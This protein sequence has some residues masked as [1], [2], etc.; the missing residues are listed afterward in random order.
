MHFNGDFET[1]G[2]NYGVLL[3]P[4]PGVFES[5]SSPLPRAPSLP[6][7]ASAKTRH[8]ASVASRCTSAA[9]GACRLLQF[10]LWGLTLL[11]TWKTLF[12]KHKSDFSFNGRCWSVNK[13]CVV[14]CDSPALQSRSTELNVNMITIKQVWESWWRRLL[15]PTSDKQVQSFKSLGVNWTLPGEIQ[16]C[17]TMLEISQLVPGNNYQHIYPCSLW[18]P[19]GITVCKHSC[20]LQFLINNIIELKAY[21]IFSKIKIKLYFSIDFPLHTWHVSLLWVGG[22]Q[23]R[24]TLGVGICE[25]NIFR[26]LGKTA[27]VIQYINTVKHCEMTICFSLTQ[28]RVKMFLSSATTTLF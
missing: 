24:R 27:S 20:T 1:H 13:P 7:T 19:E 5:T 15:Q 23:L 21:L 3:E 26:H 10:S 22:Y 18:P 17:G 6:S 16:L 14:D 9:R 12:L 25:R 28:D 8:W 11:F 4:H 2:R